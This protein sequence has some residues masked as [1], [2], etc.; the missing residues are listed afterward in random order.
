MNGGGVSR[1][2]FREGG[3]DH[4][5]RWSRSVYVLAAIFLVSAIGMIVFGRLYYL[6]ERAH[7]LENKANELTSIRDLKIDQ[8]TL[9][10]AGLLRDGRSFS[11]DPTVADEV[12]A[13]QANPDDPAAI[14]AL[15]AWMSVVV[16]RGDY[17]G[18]ILMSATGERWISSDGTT[19]PDP[20]SRQEVLAA[21][22]SQEASVTDLFLDPATGQARL[23]VVIPLLPGPEGAES[24]LVLLRNPREFLFPVL[25]SWPY[26]SPSSETL[27]VRREGDSI[28]YL[29]P[30]R[31]SASPP[32]TM[33]RPLTE[34]QLL[35]VKV[36][37][38][39]SG[40]LT[41][42][43]YNGVPAIGAGGRI[44]GTGWFMISMVSESEAYAQLENRSRQIVI[45]IF[46][47]LAFLGLG[48]V[49]AWRVRLGKYY[50]ARYEDEVARQQLSQQY[51]HLMRFASDAVI[52]S[53]EN[54]CVVQANDAAGEMLGYTAEELLGLT[55]GDLMDPNAA[56]SSDDYLTHEAGRSQVR[57][58]R[59]DGTTFEAEISTRRIDTDNE[60]LYLMISR[61]MT[62]QRRAAAA[63]RES[64]ERFRSVVMLAP[65]PMMVQAEDGSVVLINDAWTAISGY[66][67]DDIL[68][69]RAWTAKAYGSEAS[70]VDAE[71]RSLYGI[72]QPSM[73]GEYVIRTATGELRT[74]EFTSAPLGRDAHGRRLLISS[75]SDVTERKQ[76]QLELASSEARF[77]SI[78]NSSPSAMY[79]YRLHE[80]GRLEL[81][82]ANPAADKII[83]IGHAALIGLSIEE[84]FP[85]LI[86]TEVPDMYRAVARGDI[87]SQTF[88][89]PY[90]DDRT[91]GYFSVTVFRTEPGTVAVD[92]IDVT[93]R[94]RAEDELLKRTEELLRSNSELEKFAYIASHDL[95][96]PLRMITSYTQLLARRYEGQL[97]ADAQTYIGFAVDGA[98]RMQNLINELLVYSRIG[99]V[100]ESF[101]S[102]D[103]ETVLAGVLKAIEVAIGESGATV[104]HDPLPTI[105]CDPTQIGQVLQNLLT[106][107]L[108]FRS[109]APPAVH[110]GAVR[111]EGE[112][113]FSVSDNGLGIEPTYHD[114]IFV[115]FQRLESRAEYP[116]TGM[117]LAICKRV[118]ERHG[119]RIWVE[120]AVGKGSTFFFTLPDR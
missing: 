15:R 115:I 7:Q 108:K 5:G 91:T 1:R 28:V 68:T 86:D 88:E 3:T 97:D 98:K 39:A 56:D 84:A 78:V 90:E 12:D 31:F 57:H 73:E 105:A 47:I 69:T 34:S 103:L 23:D 49:L 114:L 112:W 85:A 102:S 14:K 20:V 118:I 21:A 106:N 50:R 37:S 67:A 77:R 52:L 33:K 22:G 41:G 82:S 8:I 29:N 38:G 74:W 81:T 111:G 79:L 24:V 66:T 83:G 80:D 36:A 104:T 45:A 17:S 110:I 19:P 40:I 116:G 53:D 2:T 43:T 18:A 65:F 59:K 89:M 26:P 42:V 13:W 76:A 95:Q 99:T 120:S 101:V 87:E 63:L 113:A 6:S 109:E 54:H 117:G 30:L 62:Q 100:S 60:V 10:R 71:I 72:T 48:L 94:K 96:E 64:E 16:G 119:G 32:L 44:P 27:L 61:D 35:G 75:A 51:G 70:R 58:L 4:D 25:E 107:A 46:S 9:W 92:F 55:L 93:S 11:S